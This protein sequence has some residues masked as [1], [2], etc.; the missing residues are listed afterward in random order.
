VP[1]RA[2]ATAQPLWDQLLEE[3]KRRGVS[4]HLQGLL[5]QLMPLEGPK[6]TLVLLAPNPF[7]RDW[8][9]DNYGGTL[10]ELLISTVGPDWIVE[11]R[12]EPASTQAKAAEP[13]TPRT[14][15]AAEAGLNPAYTFST[16]VL[17]KSNELVFSAA[18]SIAR[19]PGEGNNP[20]FVY[21]D[22]GLGK[23]HVLHAIGNEVLRRTPAARVRLVT[24]EQFMNEYIAVTHAGNRT[25]EKREEFR[26]RYRLDCD[27]L[28]LDDIQLWRGSAVE[29]RHEFFLTFNELYQR[30]R[31]IVITSDRPPSDLPD[32]EERLKTRFHHGLLADI[33][34][35]AFETRLAILQ[36][37]AQIRNI[38]LS[39]EV[40]AFIAER[41]R[42]N[43]RELEG[44]LNRLLAVHDLTRVPLSV[45]MAQQA[46]KSIL[47]PPQVINLDSILAET[48]RYFGVTPERL[49]R[50]GRQKRLA[51]ARAVGMYLCRTL[52][53]SSFPEIA[54]KFEKDHATVMYACRK[55]ENLL[56][57]EPSV[58]RE[59]SE[60]QAQLSNG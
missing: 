4:S 45:E 12:A 29:T 13:A 7:I 46:L 53:N 55:I 31:Q 34:P 60:V 10:R 48:A 41:V 22:S 1:P 40:A 14:G 33:Q 25:L 11:L 18:Q 47:P 27:L 15:A 35:P 39:P 16:F 5:S 21:G 28:L 24:G 43:V 52:T 56:E 2:E 17:G 9:D 49:I 57:A 54:L 19:S 38:D 51:H 8:V 26:R 32:I 20:L 6:E 42:R 37:K 44:A 36:K 58:R 59:C 23:T 30:H 50:G 3:L